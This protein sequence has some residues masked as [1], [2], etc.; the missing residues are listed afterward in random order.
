MTARPLIA[1]W[2]RAARQI[3]ALAALAGAPAILA[4]HPAAADFR[5][6][7][8]TSSRVGVAIGYKDKGGWDTEGGCGVA[9]RA[10]QCVPA[11]RG[12]NRP[13]GGL[14]RAAHRDQRDQTG[15]AER[16]ADADPDARPAGTHAAGLPPA[17]TEPCAARGRP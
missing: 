10:P 5:L 17:G 3:C 14:D 13:T 16:R 7:N 9:S 1:T 6:C 12:R 11:F 8:N 4:A 2:G 15:R